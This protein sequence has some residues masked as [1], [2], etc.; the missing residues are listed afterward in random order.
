MSAGRR[1][2]LRITITLVLSI[3]CLAGLQGG[4]V[5]VSLAEE[6]EMPNQPGLT[7]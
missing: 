5:V 4:L 3:V 7:P 2:S 1:M 6:Q